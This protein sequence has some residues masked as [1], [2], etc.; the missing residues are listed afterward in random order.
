M[1]A[2][3]NIAVDRFRKLLE[4]TLTGFFSPADAG[5]VIQEIRE[6]ISGLPGPANSHVTLVDVR[7]L[8]LQP[9]DVIAAVAGQIANPRYRSRRLA[10]VVGSSV[11]R[12]QVRRLLIRDEVGVFEDPDEAKRWLASADHGMEPKAGVSA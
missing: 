9:Q 8:K 3:Y 11:A 1:S 10:F 7:Q 12:M 2:S 6:S 4:V 5:R